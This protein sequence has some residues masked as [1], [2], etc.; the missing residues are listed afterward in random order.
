MTYATQTSGT[1]VTVPTNGREANE[2]GFYLRDYPFAN[3]S[4]EAARWI[5]EWND[6]QIDREL[7]EDENFR[8]CSAA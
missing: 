5:Q 6:A 3:G 1:K 4:A 8:R 7:W 2:Q